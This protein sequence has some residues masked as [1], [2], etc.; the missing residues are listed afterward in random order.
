M[1]SETSS[2]DIAQ[3]SLLVNT[4]QIQAL[5]NQIRYT[6][7]CAA[8]E[9][10]IG[11]ALQQVTALIDGIIKTQADILAD[12]FPILN[13]P[14]AN[15]FAI[16]KWIAKLVFGTAVT[17]YLAFVQ[18]TIQLI[19]L[20]SAL[21]DLI[22]AIESVSDVLANCSIAL[23]PALILSGHLTTVNAAIATS[24]TGVQSKHNALQTVAGSVITLTSFN[25]S[26]ASAFQ[27]SVNTNLP[28]FKTDVATFMDSSV[29]PDTVPILGQ[30]LTAN[31]TGGPY[32]SPNTSPTA[33]QILASNGSDLYWSDN[34]IMRNRIINGD[35]H[36]SQRATSATVTAGTAVPTVST[37]YPCLDRWYVYS[38]GANVT[39][40]QVS[41]SSVGASNI[42]NVMQITGAA[43][44][45]EIGVGQRIENV[46]IMD[47]SGSTCTLSAYLADSLLTI[48]TWTAYSAT[49]LNTFGTIGTPTKTQISTGTFTVT[50]TFQRYSASFNIPSGTNTG[51]EIVFTVGAQ[52]SGTLTIGNVQVEGGS[53][54]SSYETRSFSHDLILCQRYFEILNNFY[55]L[56]TSNVASFGGNIVIMQYKT[57]KRTTPTV[58]L[59]TLTNL[60]GTAGSLTT[61]ISSVVSTSTLFSVSPDTSGVYIWNNGALAAPSDYASGSLSLS[62][63]IA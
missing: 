9:I 23:D 11:R 18:Y 7:S 14:G 12:F 47:L 49:T 28:Q 4:Y 33:G 35:M 58:V 61:V 37:G 24:L 32:W 27:T 34:N 48:V 38:T 50:S 2:H 26:N 63:E 57:T 43:S 53:F 52:T 17:Q 56:R 6:T 42:R 44:V 19:Q 45:T 51:I 46:N 55:Y 40:A 31:A 8:L 5:A 41:G 30:V 62:A 25:T 13:L 22:S 54:A 16:V 21:A 36:I 39:A 15:P 10:V 3:G 20:A 29:I 59:Y 1:S 60:T